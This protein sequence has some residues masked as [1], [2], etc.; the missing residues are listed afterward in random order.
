MPIPAP[1][2]SSRF[3][4]SGSRMQVFIEKASLYDPFLGLTS[5]NE[6][7]SLGS[8]VS[9]TPSGT[10]ES[11]PLYGEGWER[12]TKNG[13]SG[14]ISLVTFAPGDQA[15]V[16][17]LIE[18][19]QARG[20]Q[21]QI[22][23][24]FVLP[25]GG[26]VRGAAVVSEFVSN[27]AV[28]GVLSY[29]FNLLTDG[30]VIVDS[31]RP[32][33]LF[34]S[35]GLWDWFTSGEPRNVDVLV[36]GG[37]GGGGNGGV[38]LAGGG[39]G[40][41]GIRY[42]PGV[43]VSG[44]VAVTVGLGGNAG[45]NGSPSSFGLAYT[46]PGGGG[47]GTGS[48]TT[49]SV[50]DGASGASGGGAGAANVTG[51]AAFNGVGGLGFAPYGTRGSSALDG[52]IAGG[53]GG[54]TGQGGAQPFVPRGTFVYP[55]APASVESGTFFNEFAVG[56]GLPALFTSYGNVSSFVIVDGAFVVGGT[57]FQEFEDGPGVPA[58]FTKYTGVAVSVSVSLEAL[59]AIGA[60]GGAG[61][62]L[63]ALGLGLA[64]EFGVP[65][66]FCGGGGGGTRPL[67]EPLIGAPGGLG[68]GG[69]GAGATQAAQP[70]V[71]GRGGGGGGGNEI[72]PTG[73]V[74][75]LGFVLVRN[76]S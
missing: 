61:I 30:P 34:T 25:D 23:Y 7:P 67:F 13:L 48:V 57:N 52:I 64:A 28:R 70:G 4:R 36:V 73:A 71:N 9:F 6:L 17:K 20:P 74:G 2:L 5:F 72:F 22:V 37:G 53:G 3:L 27:T 51:S 32:F 40:A 21:A 29:S 38:G 50:R 12:A 44:P 66:D 26:T 18:A 63:D 24:L 42:Y 58:G 31:L 75:G 33:Q 10:T 76:A 15:V 65:A 46:A 11:T 47:G 59:P 8:D 41:G 43:P 56:S 55:S 68:G 45:S 54:A 39:G 1:T 69:R 16:N 14:T 35:S 60:R 62:T 49:P 19:S